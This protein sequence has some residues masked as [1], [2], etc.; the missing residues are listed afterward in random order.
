MITLAHVRNLVT[1]APTDSIFAFTDAVGTGDRV[2]AF[3]ALAAL[4]QAR[5][6]P[7]YLLTMLTRQFRLL[8]SAADLLARGTHPTNLATELK[9]APFVAQKLTQQARHASVPRLRDAF[10]ALA[11]LDH[12]LKSSRAP[13]QALVDLFCLKVST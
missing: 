10:L 9:V 4:E 3:R 12:R 7:Q 5:V 6:D 8:V 2:A 11:A 13:W 1:T